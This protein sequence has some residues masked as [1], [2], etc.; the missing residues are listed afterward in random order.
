M[1]ILSSASFKDC[2][3]NILNSLCDLTN[4]TGQ[5]ALW[6]ETCTDSVSEQILVYSYNPIATTQTTYWYGST[7]GVSVGCTPGVMPHAS[8]KKYILDSIVGY[9]DTANPQLG[10]STAGGSISTSLL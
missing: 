7:P 8:Y 1:T 10:N 5:N 9:L 3:K 2:Y 4:W 6:I